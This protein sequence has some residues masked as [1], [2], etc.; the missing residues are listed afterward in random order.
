MRTPFRHVLTAACLA[1]LAGCSADVAAPDAVAPTASRP[2]LLLAAGEGVRIISDT[3][4]AAGTT[5]MVG[6]YA[7]G[8][9]TLPDGTGGSVASVTIKTVI[10]GLASGSSSEPCITSSIVTVETTS[11]WKSSV[12]KPGGCDKE[13]VV[14]LENAATRQRAQFSFLYI[15]GKTRID[16]GLIR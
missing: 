7:A 6:E 12:K 10:P 2:S 16:S 8:V 11:G 9:Y 13:I 5:T 15:F 3:T 4:D 1:A 14:A